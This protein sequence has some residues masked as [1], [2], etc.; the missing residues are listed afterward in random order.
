[1]SAADDT[2]RTALIAVAA[3]VVKGWPLPEAVRVYIAD[4][5]T[6]STELSLLTLADVH[7]WEELAPDGKSHPFLYT[8]EPSDKHPHGYQIGGAHYPWKGVMLRLVAAEDLPD[9]D[10]SPPPEPGPTED[11]E[12]VLDAAKEAI[13]PDDPVHQ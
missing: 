7:R 9:P 4:D 1:V 2:L 11:E 3:Q 6:P 13:T 10:A 5:G 12:T 8:Y